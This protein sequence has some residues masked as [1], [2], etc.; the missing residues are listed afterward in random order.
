MLIDSSRV[1]QPMTE[2]SSSAS[3]RVQD[4]VVCGI[5][6]ICVIADEI[7]APGA[8]THPSW[9][10]VIDSSL[11]VHSGPGQSIFFADKIKASGQQILRLAI[12][13]ID[14]SVVFAIVSK[15][16][17]V[18]PIYCGRDQGRGPSTHRDCNGDVHCHHGG[19]FMSLWRV[20]SIAS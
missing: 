17:F 15:P 20:G 6:F 16:S 12:E 2:L 14:I 5:C 10:L 19:G 11:A 3:R 1:R 8:L 9:D 4:H 13:P 18:S 7:Q